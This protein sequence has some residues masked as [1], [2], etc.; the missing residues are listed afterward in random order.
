ME[1]LKQVFTD[2]SSP[3]PFNISGISIDTRT[4]QKGDL[5]FCLQGEYSDGH[6]FINEA[7]TKGAGA[8]VTHEE[9][10]SLKDYPHVKVKDTLDGL[11]QLGAAGRKR[12]PAKIA[13]LTGSAGKT[14]TKEMLRQI[15]EFH[16]ETVYSP[17]SYNNHWGVPYSLSFLTTDSEYGI[18]ELGM[19]NGGEIEPLTKLVQPDVA[20]ITNIFEAHIGFMGS[21]QA[22][23]EEKS[24]IFAGLKTNGTAVLP[25]D[26]EFYDFLLTKAKEYSISNIITFG[27]DPSADVVLEN[28]EP[29]SDKHQS[30]V[31]VKAFGKTYK[32]TLNFLGLHYAIN[33]LAVL[34]CCHGMK[35]PL[36][37]AAS[38]FNKIYPVDGR[39]AYH[40][41][42]LPVGTIF[43]IDDAYNANPASMKSG[44]SVLATTSTNSRRI[45]VLGDMKE[46]GEHSINY[47]KE[48]ARFMETLDID[49][50]FTAGIDMKHC[51]EELPKEMQGAHSA[52][53][54]DLIPILREQLK[55]EDVVFVKGSKSSYI[56]YV[57]D[58]LKQWSHESTTKI[59][60]GNS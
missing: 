9:N 26:D 48:I 60:N 39:G 41:L 5:F 42:P 46:L 17:A 1:E 31:T 11:K 38:I 15:C 36:S 8:I 12:S 35:I 24:A 18:F 43:L 16:G 4:M 28:Y 20:V 7:I 19:N 33:S 32:Y 29:V 10:K 53:V 52:T 3:S 56:S 30:I 59:I 51:F 21:K 57:V 22:I 50:V 25:R 13:A 2:V 34:A 44:I 37:S 58:D 45:A 27:E 47:H 6:Q 54:Q 23:A 40:H 49:L 14:T 55:D